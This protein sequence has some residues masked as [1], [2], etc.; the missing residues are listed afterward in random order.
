[1]LLK[2]PPLS[3]PIS[4]AV[5]PAL[6]VPAGAETPT[7]RSRLAAQ[8]RI[9]CF[10]RALLRR[11]LLT[12]LLQ[13]S[14]LTATAM[15]AMACASSLLRPQRGL[16]PSKSVAFR[17]SVRPVKRAQLTTASAVPFDAAA[18]LTTG[19]PVVAGP[20]CVEPVHLPSSCVWRSQQPSPPANSAALQAPELLPPPLTPAARFPTPYARVQRP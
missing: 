20:S 17:R 4:R 8:L 9:H 16:L 2:T 19:N 1:M 12:T 10:R 6:R 15:A 3:P 14:A 5:L 11:G 18:L 13:A 7:I